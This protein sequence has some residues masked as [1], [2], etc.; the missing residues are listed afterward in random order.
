MSDLNYRPTFS[1]L[2]ECPICVDYYKLP[3]Y[4]CDQGHSLCSRCK[5][6]SRICPQCRRNFLPNSRNIA[7]EK[8]MEQ[9]SRKCKFSECGQDISLDQWHNHQS[10]CKYNPNLK[11]IECGSSE[12]Y[13]IQHLI[14]AHEYK[15]IAMDSNECIRSFSGPINSWTGNTEWPKGIWKFGD[16]YL[17]VKAKAIDSIFHIFLYRI[18]KA[19]TNVTLI[20]RNTDDETSI[21]FKGDLPHISEFQELCDIPHFNCEVKQLMNFVKIQEGDSEN[22][23][24]TVH[25]T[26]KTFQPKDDYEEMEINTD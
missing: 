7:M 13:L 22:F 20:I 3:I 11:C 5:E 18:T 6:R 8:M 21:K 1:E 16:E 19:I 17:L 23:K 15:E 24:L 2:F 14:R 25:V 26:K 12:E 4:L 10:E 9:V